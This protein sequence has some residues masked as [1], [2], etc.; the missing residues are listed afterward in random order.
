MTYLSDGGLQSVLV[1]IEGC[2][3]VACLALVASL[4]RA[5]RSGLVTCACICIYMYVCMYVYIYI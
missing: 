5:K 3:H 2:I 1:S 4:P